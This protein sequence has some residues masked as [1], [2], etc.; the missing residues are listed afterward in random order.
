MT[1]F[2]AIPMLDSG[3]YPINAGESRHCAGADIDERL[4]C[5]IYKGLNIVQMEEHVKFHGNFYTT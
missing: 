3:Q 2:A 5:K 4:V 1:R